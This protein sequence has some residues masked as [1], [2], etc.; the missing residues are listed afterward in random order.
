MW[1][2]CRLS[3]QS[4]F[5][6]KYSSDEPWNNKLDAMLRYAPETAIDM[7][8]DT[9]KWIGHTAVDLYDSGA[10]TVRKTGNFLDDVNDFLGPFGW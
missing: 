6:R 4:H 7:V 9:G 2:C 8:G 5:N 3:L 10:R 1:F